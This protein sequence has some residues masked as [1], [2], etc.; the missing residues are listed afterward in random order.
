VRCQVRMSM[1]RPLTGYHQDTDMRLSC[2]H[3]GIV[4][5]LGLR[6]NRNYFCHVWPISCPLMGRTNSCPLL[7][8]RGALTLSEKNKD[9]GKP[10]EDGCVEGCHPVHRRTCVVPH[11]DTTRMRIAGRHDHVVENVPLGRPREYRRLARG[12]Q[13]FHGR[14]IIPKLLMFPPIPSTS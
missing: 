12:I 9:E 6:L 13:G 1:A 4:K 11:P 10:I 7:S 14:S 8:W 2:C 3:T 5:Q